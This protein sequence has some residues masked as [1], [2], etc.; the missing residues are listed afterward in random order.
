MAANPYWIRL[1]GTGGP[2]EWDKGRRFGGH[3]KSKGVETLTASWDGA[4]VVR[5]QMKNGVTWATVSLIPWGAQGNMRGV[6]R[7][8][9]D[10][11]IDGSEYKPPQDPLFTIP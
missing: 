7:I 8:L 4:V 10:G 5:V 6:D 11:P 1:R 9:Y 2:G 3:N